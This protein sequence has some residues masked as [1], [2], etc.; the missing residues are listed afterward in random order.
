[1]QP[2]DLNTSTKIVDFGVS[3]AIVSDKLT[4]KDV[5]DYSQ[6]TSYMGRVWTSIRLLASGK[7]LLNES[8]LNQIYGELPPLI[9]LILKTYQTSIETSLTQS[10]EESQPLV[11][12]LS[13]RQVSKKE[14]QES[15]WFNCSFSQK[16][17]AEEAQIE[18]L[19]QFAEQKQGYAQYLY[20]DAESVYD[21]FKETIDET[22][23]TLII[24]DEKIDSKQKEKLQNIK[25][26]ISIE[27]ES[28]YGQIYGRNLDT[29]LPTR[30]VIA[31]QE[32]TLDANCPP[33]FK[34][35]Q[36]NAG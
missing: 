32:L 3:S 19:E 12:D 35:P 2:T 6:T 9:S 28:L 25:N 16:D 13:S 22:K 18:R 30:A 31:L 23:L 20:K 33:I 24:N 17:P 15:S 1:M 10:S 26:F 11:S 7:G 27:K 14:T 4:W 34:S 21:M 5:V 8:K 29:M 36:N